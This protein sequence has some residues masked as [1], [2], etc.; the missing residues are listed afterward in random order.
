MGCPPIASSAQILLLAHN[1]ILPLQ[2]TG[3]GKKGS[4]S[5]LAVVGNGQGTAGFGL[6]KDMEA[7]TA[8]VK[9]CRAAKK[10]M[11]HVERFDKRTVFHDMEDKWAKT[12]VC[13]GATIL[14]HAFRGVAHA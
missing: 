3:A 10:N 4:V 2:V 12:K 7:T 13:R 1:S 9:A 5:V 6:G 11:L 8:L 14:K